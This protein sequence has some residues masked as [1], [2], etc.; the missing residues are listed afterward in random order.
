M[1]VDRMHPSVDKSITFAVEKLRLA[2]YAGFWVVV[3]TGIVLTRFFSGIDLNDT[4]LVQVFGYNNICVYFDYPPS[5]YVLPFLWAITL[6]LLLTYI[7]AHW[8]RMRAEVQQGTLSQSLYRTLAGLKGFEAFTLVSFSTIFAVSP[9]GHDHTLFIHTAPFFLLQIGMVSLAMSNTLHGMQSGYWRRLGLPT[10]FM[11]GAI[12]YCMVFALI[13]AFKIPVATNAMA[14]S[15]WWVQTESLGRLA[16]IV[17]KGFLICAAIIPMMKASYLV[18]SRPDAI[19]VV[20]LA[21]SAAP[22]ARGSVPR[23]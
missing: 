5:N 7:A 14:G 4:L 10:W 15:R 1:V 2:G 22:R 21:P 13:V 3:V 18:Y 6:V 19:D 23:G 17:D 9:E 8:L 20:R 16:G 11:R 12:V